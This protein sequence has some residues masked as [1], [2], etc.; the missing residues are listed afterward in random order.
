M[1][2]MQDRLGRRRRARRG[3]TA[4][5][6]EAYLARP[7]AALGERAR[8]RRDL[9]PAACPT[10]SSACTCWSAHALA[11]GPGVNP[12]GD[13]ALALLPD[14]WAP[15]P[16]A[17]RGPR[18]GDM[19]RVAAID[20][21]TNSIRLLVA[22][23]DP[24]PATLVD[25]DRRDGDRAPRRR[26]R[27]HRAARRRRAGAHVRGVRR[28]RRGDPPA[29]AP[30]RIRFVATSASRDAENRDEFVA[31][32]PR[33]ARGRARGGQRRGGGR[34]LLRRRDPRPRRRP[35]RPYLV[36]DIGGGSTELVLGDDEP[37]GAARERRHRL[38][39][40]DRAPLPARDPPDRR[41]RS[42]AATADIDAA[43]A[44]CAEVVPLANARDPGRA[45]R[46]GDHRRRDRAA[47]AG[48]RPGRDPRLAHPAR[49]RDGRCPTGCCAMTARAGGDPGDAPRPGRRDRRRAR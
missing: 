7:R 29:R 20:C 39:A 12:L 3:A 38:R 4:A 24:A 9:A 47:P 18:A 34:A 30:T 8:D 35:T 23:V 26:R 41:A 25:L 32:V 19:T 40:D 36:V 6:H 11:A 45:R 33:P 46:L 31:G 1:R 28:V 15:G 13:E 17:G 44:R 48:V 22:D 2:E 42:R 37:R 5:A 27:P 14:W 16:C 49:G 43:L 10:G 21:G